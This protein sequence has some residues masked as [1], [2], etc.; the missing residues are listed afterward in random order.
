MAWKKNIRIE[1][2]ASVSCLVVIDK[3][4]ID[5]VLRNLLT[6]AIKFSYPGGKITILT[7]PDEQFCRIMVIDEGTGITEENLRNLFQPGKRILSSG[8]I[9]EKGSGLGLLL[10]KEFVEKNK[11][12]IWVR[13]EPGKGSEF[14]FTLPRA[15][16]GSTQNG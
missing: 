4:M 5:T 8:T 2:D 12:E 16:S 10:C 14:I 13:S 11:G 6:N 15:H 3:N 9:Q 7:E 1:F